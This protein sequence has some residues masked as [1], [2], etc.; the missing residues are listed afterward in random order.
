MPQHRTLAGGGVA[1]SLVTTTTDTAA[2]EQSHH[3]AVVSA[4]TSCTLD[5]IL[6]IEETTSAEAAWF[7]PRV[8]RGRCASIKCRLRDWQNF[9]TRT[10]ERQRCMPITF[11]VVDYPSSTAVFAHDLGRGQ[12][13]WDVDRNP[14]LG[15][16]WSPSSMVTR[17]IFNVPSCSALST[18]NVV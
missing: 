16:K 2:V 14:A 10:A 5:H 7:H 13:P 6:S 17:H 3:C 4:P 18:K 1:P 8:R 12:I 11:H 15:T 9:V